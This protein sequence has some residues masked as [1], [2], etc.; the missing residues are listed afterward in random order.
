M[1]AGR[2]LVR[3]T[4][5][6]ALLIV[7]WLAVS[8]PLLMADAF[9]PVPAVALFVP[10]A[11]AALWFG[12]R[13]RGA[14]GAATDV[15][16]WPVLAVFGITVAFLVLQVVMSA[17]QI[18]VRR[19]PAS[20]VQFT[21][22]LKNE[23]SLPIPL[24]DEAFGG[25]DPALRFESPAFY[26]R[27]GA[28]VPQFMAGLPLVLTLGGWIG[29][30]HGILLMAPLLGACCVLAFAG[31]VARLVSPRW[32]PAGALL[33]ALTLPMLYVSRS[34]FSELPAIVLLLGGLSLMHDVRTETGRL[35]DAKA[36]LA[37]LALGLIVLVRID[38]LRDVLPV[39]VFAGLY[40]AHRRRAGYWTAGGLLLGVGAGLL[41][42]FTLS[43]PYLTYLGASL[44]PLLAIAAVVVAATLI[45]VVLLRRERTGSRLRRLGTVVARGRLPGVAAVLTVLVMVGFAVR[46]WVQ[47]VRREPATRDDE[48]NVRFIETI[49]RIQHLPVDGTRQYSEDSLHWVS[50]YI[51]PPALLF[52]TV[53]AALLAR[54]LLRGRSTEWLLPYAMIVWT[55]TQVLIRPGITPDHPWASRR[56]IGLVVPGLLLFTVFASAWAARRVRRLGYGRRL[57]RAGAVVG[58]AMML[59]PI[60]LVSGGLLVTR[61][62]QHEVAAV[63]G[64]CDAL[65]PR[66]SVVV[67]EQ[68]TADRF[69]QVVRGM[70]GVPAA[71]TTG[72]A[73]VADVRRVVA[74]VAEAGRRPVIMAA[75]AEQVA[76][77]G[78]PRRVLSLRTRQDG[79][80]LTG[81]PGGTWGLSME[82]W[83]AEPPRR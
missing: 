13:T 75:R 70:C 45:M 83:I 34:A 38:G 39:F 40:V 27:D 37:G 11:A 74:G 50:W 30:T 77:Y 1:D 29:G 46:P 49:Q 31:L 6:P 23:G 67:V 10:V 42:G 72:N 59:V 80:T 56:L 79:R 41:E 58:V 5:A 18:V 43:R 61:T 68:S 22:W 32:A 62:E 16:W 52:A 51:G 76:P 8:L 82:V 24:M 69:L 47:T 44:D 71:R 35:A 63:D 64:M 48:M 21:T 33:L 73:T 36:F 12:L 7:A 4:V 14:G 2:L 78:T 53:G 65:D 9:R 17:E 54:R 26:E 60:V 55:T 25:S 66:G 81:P 20:Y 15:P 28:V 57:V 19:D 3:V